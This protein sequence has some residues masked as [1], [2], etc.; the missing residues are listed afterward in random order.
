MTLVSDRSVDMELDARSQRQLALRHPK[1]VAGLVLLGFFVLLIV[2]HPL[3]QATVW[4]GQGHLY[5]PV[6]GFD[7]DL[8]HPSG[9]S[10]IHWLGTDSLGRDVFAMLTFAA[11]P[12]VTVAV[13]SG[14]IIGLVSLAL[15]SLAG[16]RRGW[17]DGLISHIS[18]AFVL[19]PALLAVFIVGVGRPDD[20]FGPLQVGLVFG[21]VYGL[22]PA[23]ATV[24][25][26]ALGVMAKPF[27][28]AARVSGGGGWW[29]VTRHVLP[30]LVQ[31]AAVQTMIGVTGAVVAEAF[32]SFRSAVGDTVGFGQM[33]YDGLTWNTL[34]AGIAET[35]WWVMLSGA[36][37]ITGLAAS[38]FLLGIGLREAFDPNTRDR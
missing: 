4:E 5:N 22:G 15:G 24:R 33:V 9:P 27:L 18:D 3:L 25:T 21:L 35:P 37:G 16:Y 14:V 7:R 34:M 11:R 23:T 12:T 29:M 19:L 10:G 38:F 8:V 6:V 30:H 13:S 20:Q 31:H 2:A 1:V 28:D 17:I 26:A 32:L 36:A